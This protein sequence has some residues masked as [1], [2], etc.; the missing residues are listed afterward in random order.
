MAK[1]EINSLFRTAD[2]DMS[3]KISIDEFT[4]VMR[5]SDLF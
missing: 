2:S 3:G 5:R 1:E 4:D